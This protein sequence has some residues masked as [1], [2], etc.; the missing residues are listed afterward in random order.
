[1]RNGDHTTYSIN[2]KWLMRRNFKSLV[3]NNINIDV[4]DNGGIDY[5]GNDGDDNDICHVI[6]NIISDINVLIHD[7][8]ITQLIM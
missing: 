6:N 7:Y 4:C 8:K 1:V 2:V 3:S 5:R